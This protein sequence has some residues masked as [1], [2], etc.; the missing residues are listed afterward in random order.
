MNTLLRKVFGICSIIFLFLESGAQNI[1]GTWKGTLNVQG[2]QIPLVFHIKKDSA[3]KW[4]AAFESP[5][6]H[7]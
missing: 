6:Q 3:K 5:G 7:I 1:T 4:I 2:N